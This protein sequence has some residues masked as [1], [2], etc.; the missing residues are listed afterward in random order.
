[1]PMSI[2]EVLDQQSQYQVDTSP[3]TITQAVHL[4][5]Q[6]FPEGEVTGMSLP[7]DSLGAYTVNLTLP[8][9]AKTGNRV[10]LFVDQYSGAT[11][12]SSQDEPYR[13][14]KSYLNWV[15]PLHYGTFG[16]LPTRILALLASLV[17]AALFLTGF[18]IWLP[19][20]KKRRML[21]KKVPQSAPQPTVH[22]EKN[23][24]V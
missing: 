21:G 12:G 2:S 18:F 11:I 3:I 10:L 20:W 7:H 1:S 15:Q 13:L 8:S 9:A 16:G 4:A 5:Q 14:A 6:K 19:R 24:I 23:P 17:T 22:H